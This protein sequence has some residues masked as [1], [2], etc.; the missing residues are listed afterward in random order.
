MMRL[1]KNFKDIK[2]YKINILQNKYKLDKDK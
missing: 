1:L 2:E